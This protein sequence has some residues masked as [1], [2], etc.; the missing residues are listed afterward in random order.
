MGTSSRG[1]PTR[2]V[3]RWGPPLVLAAILI[4]LLLTARRLEP[5]PRGYG[6]HTQLGLGEC[7]F[8]TL[9]GRPCPSCGMTTALAWLT[10]GSPMRAWRANPAGCL[11]GLLIPFVAAWLLLCVWLDRPVGFRS[12]DRPLMGLVLAVVLLSVV[13]WILRM[14]GASAPLGLGGVAAGGPA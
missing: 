1:V 9:T 12:I 7:T 3:S 11:I 13:F 4:G 8:A 6:T 10:R 14:L 5:D 2:D